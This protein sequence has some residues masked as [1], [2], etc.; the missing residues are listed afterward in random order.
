VSAERWRTDGDGGAILVQ[1]FVERMLELAF[2]GL[3]LAE[4]S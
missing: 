4:R 2:A 1:V 3:C